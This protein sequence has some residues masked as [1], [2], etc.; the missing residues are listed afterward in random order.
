[1]YLN[2]AFENMFN[3]SNVVITSLH[4]FINNFSKDG[5]SKITNENISTLTHQNNSV[6]EQ[7]V[8]AK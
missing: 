7:L 2:I 6:C 3:M 4:D 1:M 8:E 5:I